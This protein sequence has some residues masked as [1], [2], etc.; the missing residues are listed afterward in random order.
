MKNL[1]FDLRDYSKTDYDFVYEA[2]KLGYKDY[3]EMFYG[4]WNDVQQHEMFEAYI[5]EREN[6]ITIIEVNGKNAGFIDVSESGDFLEIGNICL[7]PEF[8]GRGIGSTFFQSILEER[9]NQNM[10]LR[11]FKTN[12]AKKL[13]ERFGFKVTSETQ[14]HLYMERKKG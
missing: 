2:K 5:N 13:Y 6:Y 8:R 7:I 4:K 12:P 14:T 11:V 1:K 3:V 10:K 9:P